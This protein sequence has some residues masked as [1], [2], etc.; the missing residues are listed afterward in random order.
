MPN[1]DFENF[2]SVTITS[3]SKPLSGQEHRSSDNYDFRNL[4]K[5]DY[6]KLKW[7]CPDGISFDVMEDKSAAKDPVTFSNVKNGTITNFPSDSQANGL[8][9]ANPKFNSNDIPSL[10]SFEISIEPTS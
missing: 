1:Y 6:S 3:N 4:L 8:Y 9:I 10:Y 5:N 2:L 7:I